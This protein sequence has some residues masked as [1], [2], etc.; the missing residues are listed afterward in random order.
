MSGITHYNDRKD[1]SATLSDQPDVLKEFLD[2][3]P[4][5]DLDLL[6]GLY[7]A[8]AFSPVLLLSKF[9]FKTNSQYEISLKDLFMVSE[10]FPC[11][12]KDD[13]KLTR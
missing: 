3:I 10:I 6:R 4:R 13:H 2:V 12:G 7:I 8:L 9:D 5:T 11:A 1:L